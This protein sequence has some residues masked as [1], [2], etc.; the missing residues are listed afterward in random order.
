M[1]RTTSRAMAQDFE[2]FSSD[3]GFEL[4][5]I[6]IPVHLWQGDADANVPPAHA[7]LQH[8][9][10]PGSVLHECPGEAHLLVVDHLVEIATTVRP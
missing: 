1:S 8:H 7:A 4:S 10:I 9:E 3:W 6:A 5:R 2:L